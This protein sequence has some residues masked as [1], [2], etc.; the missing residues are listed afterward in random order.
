MALK[1]R[2]VLEPFGLP[3]LGQVRGDDELIRQA[4]ARFEAMGLDW[5]AAETRKLVAQP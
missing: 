2:T 3:A 5:H 1:P 4:L